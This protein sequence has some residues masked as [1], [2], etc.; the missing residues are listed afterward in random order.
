DVEHYA[1]M[2]QF[3]LVGFLVSGL[4]L[5]RAYFDYF[6]AIV[7]CIIIL[8][9]CVRERLADTGEP[10]LASVPVPRPGYAR[11]PRE[12]SLPGQGFS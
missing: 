8:D 6:F 3:S 1:H 4:F 11:S 10:A 12:F 5:G 2:F 7:A 9:R